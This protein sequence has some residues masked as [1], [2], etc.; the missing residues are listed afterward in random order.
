MRRCLQWYEQVRGRE[1]DI[2]MVA[3]MRIH[4]ER[5]KERWMDTVEDDML[6]RYRSDKDNRISLWS[7]SGALQERHPSRIKLER[8]RNIFFDH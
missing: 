8:V 2:R 1:E 5:S 7:L 3:E 6:R 4:G